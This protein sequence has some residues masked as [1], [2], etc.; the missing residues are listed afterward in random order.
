M[1]TNYLSS[2]PLIGRP[3]PRFG[4]SLAL[5]ASLFGVGAGQLAVQASDVNGASLP[6]IVCGVDTVLDSGG[7]QSILLTSGGVPVSPA[8]IDP[9][10][11]GQTFAIHG[12][13]V[14]RCGAN[15]AFE[16]VANRTAN[17][18]SVALPAS[19]AWLRGDR[20]G[21]T[22]GEMDTLNCDGSSTQGCTMLLPVATESDAGRLRSVVW[23]AMQVAETGANSH[24]GRLLGDATSALEQGHRG[25]GPAPRPRSS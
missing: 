23:V 6:Y 18:G 12:P 5:A 10:A 20:A 1:I 17:A 11:I 4:V 16:G 14:A 21:P 7:S 9:A 13:T 24:S 25:G 2:V 19:L 3:I 8:Q 15:Q 22:D